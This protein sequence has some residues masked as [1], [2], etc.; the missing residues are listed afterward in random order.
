MVQKS[1]HNEQTMVINNLEIINR[2]WG[3]QLPEQCESTYKHFLLSYTLDIER[4][5]NDFLEEFR[6]TLG[7]ADD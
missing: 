5:S 4:V 3:G 1:Q 7:V 2:V 6:E